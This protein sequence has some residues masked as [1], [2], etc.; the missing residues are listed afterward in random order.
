MKTH[1]TPD[2]RIFSHTAVEPYTRKNGTQTEL[3]I[4]EAKCSR[5]DCEKTFTVKTPAG[6]T[7]DS[8]AFG[9][10]HCDDHKATAISSFK[11]MVDK[12][13][14]LSDAD[15][16]EIRRLAEEGHKPSTLAMVFPVAEDTI[17]KI[18]TGRRR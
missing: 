9:R 3:K 4:W 12:S 16:A 13:R 5:Q 1:I 11:N 7:A 10:K 8:K 15:V 17:R 6:G 2:G 18:L 14:V